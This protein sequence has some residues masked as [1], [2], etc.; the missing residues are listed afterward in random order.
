MSSRQF[1]FTKILKH[2]LDGICMQINFEQLNYSISSSS[3]HT[4]TTTAATDAISPLPVQQPTL[5]LQ[6]ER[7]KTRNQHVFKTD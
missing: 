5:Q 2:V 7:K 6:H 1:F 3:P 4:S